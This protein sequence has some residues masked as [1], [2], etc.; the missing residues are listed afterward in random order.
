MRQVIPASGRGLGAPLG[1]GMEDAKFVAYVQKF[2]TVGSSRAWG[3]QF[4]VA[5][6][7]L[8]LVFVPIHLRL[9]ARHGYR[10]KR[11]PR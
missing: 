3:M 9:G 2:A 8:G 10:L 7:Q 6:W 4:S 1:S 5:T 11:C